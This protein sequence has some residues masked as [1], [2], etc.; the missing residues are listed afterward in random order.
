M[1][2]SMFPSIKEVDAPTQTSNVASWDDIPSSMLPTIKE[3]NARIQSLYND[4][5][6]KI[7][8]I[9]YTIIQ[10]KDYMYVCV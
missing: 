6:G 1:P 10:Y 4:D 9:I 8:N 7:T 3:V 2:S 5:H